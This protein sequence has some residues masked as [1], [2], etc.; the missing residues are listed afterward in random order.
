MPA[1][2]TPHPATLEINPLRRAPRRQP[3]TRPRTAEADERPTPS[4]AAQSRSSAS[5]RHRRGGRRRWPCR[6]APRA[7][8][9]RASARPRP[10]RR[11]PRR[12]PRS[13]R[14]AAR[15]RRRARPHGHRMDRRARQPPAP[16]A[17]R[18]SAGVRVDHHAEH[19]VDQ[20]DRL[21]AGRARPP[22]TS[23]TRSG[24]GAELGPAGRPQPRWPA[25]TAALTARRRGRTV[26]CATLEV[27]ARQVDLDRD[28]LGRRAGEQLGGR[29]GSRRRCGPRCWP[30]PRAPLATQ[31]AAA[32]RSATP[33]RPG[34]AGRRR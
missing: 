17:Q 28:H 21:G 15:R 6:P 16:A 4:A 34:P 10:T 33:P 18:R 8:P 24:V 5:T 31:R 30:R 19:R 9:R 3:L 32:R 11:R 27:G 12:R 13:A 14:R 7:T 26:P 22:A 29:G 2:Y 23:T 25:I 20:R 1:P